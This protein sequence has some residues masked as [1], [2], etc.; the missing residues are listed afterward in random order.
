MRK[1]MNSSEA[2]AVDGGEFGAVDDG[3]FGPVVPLSPLGRAK[4]INA[5]ASLPYGYTLHSDE[6]VMRCITWAQGFSDQ[7]HNAAVEIVA[8]IALHK[9]ESIGGSG[10]IVEGDR[11]MALVVAAADAVVSVGAGGMS[12]ADLGRSFGEEKQRRAAEISAEVKARAAA[13]K[14]DEAAIEDGIAAAFA[15]P[16]KSVGPQVVV[17]PADEDNDEDLSEED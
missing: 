10:W 8:S 2:P 5:L 4:I 3:D 7:L 13:D 17:I 6:A 1:R 16:P 14:S 9:P 11:R 12:L 15:P